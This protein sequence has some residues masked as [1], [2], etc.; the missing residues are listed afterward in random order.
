M[1]RT[2]AKKAALRMI[3]ETGEAPGARRVTLESLEKR[4]HIK[5][6]GSE[7]ELT[8][9]GAAFLE[10][11][12]GGG[13]LGHRPQFGAGGYQAPKTRKAGTKHAR[14][15]N[16]K[17][18]QERAARRQEKEAL[19]QR[20]ALE[21][22][23]LRRILG[24][25]GKAYAVKIAP[26]DGGLI[27]RLDGDAFQAEGWRV[28]SAG[29]APAKAGTALPGERRGAP[30]FPEEPEGR[31]DAWEPF[32]NPD[33]FGPEGEARAV[34]LARSKPIREAD[35]DALRAK[36]YD[37][38]PA[39]KR[40]REEPPTVKNPKTATPKARILALMVHAEGEGHAHTAAEIAKAAGMTTKATTAALEGLEKAGQ[41]YR[42]KRHWRPKIG[43]P[44]GDAYGEQKAAARKAAKKAA[45]WYG[46]DALVTPPR[47]LKGFTF[48]D[49][50]VEVGEITAIEYESKKFDGKKRIYRH[51]VTGKRKLLVSVDGTTMIVF[52]GFKITKRGIEG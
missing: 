44:P 9:R 10:G 40:Y 12:L 4:G 47:K 49:A 30:S 14:G 43:N 37:L 33:P 52:P 3:R 2:D 17:L 45:D 51:D 7:W 35:L 34:V 27:N 28:L 39:P 1:G 26:A 48:P 32:W 23:A 19:A 50:F 21:A 38:S 15:F 41:V 20:K 6:K 16:P 31:G 5:P 18:A 36:G 24:T 22:P 46:K 11:R 13:N 25:R 8:K 42:F 29:T